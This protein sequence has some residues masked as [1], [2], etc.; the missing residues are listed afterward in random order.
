[1]CRA[2]LLMVALGACHRDAPAPPTPAPLFSSGVDAPAPAPVLSPDLDAS[3]PDASPRALALARLTKH[4]ACSS[5]A[6]AVVLPS[7]T[8]LPWDDGKAKTTQ[9]R[10]DMPDIEDIFALGYPRP[11]TPI[12]PVTDPER[13]PGRVRVEPLFAATYGM[14][15][16]AVES[17]LVP[18]KLA[19][20][21]VRFH[22]KAAPAL[23][24]VAKRLDALFAEDPTL[25]R[26][27][28]DLGGTYNHR[29]IAGTDHLSAHSWGIAVDI[30]TALSDYW[31]NG[32]QPPTW[33][34]RIAQ[35]VVDAFEA[36]GFVWGG[37][38]Y[39]YDTMHFEYR[40]EL[41]GLESGP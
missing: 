29:V 19:G 18:V 36:E 35:S 34:N 16:H 21:T 25:R 5:A 24:R 17:A 8:R 6:D 40:P 37:R 2:L 20:Q 41:A 28:K 30:G 4:Y 33:R 11:E 1:M 9:Q 31:R 15:A 14:D 7:G 32:P 10:I 3:G 27:F 39:H 12:T 26:F 38:W 13:D 23:A 22:E